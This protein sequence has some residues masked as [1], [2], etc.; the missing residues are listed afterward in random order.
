MFFKD[1]KLCSFHGQYKKL[2][3]REKQL[4]EDTFQGLHCLS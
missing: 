2:W 4:C 3:F 1:G